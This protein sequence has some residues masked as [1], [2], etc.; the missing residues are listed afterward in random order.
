M[1]I[2]YIYIYIFPSTSLENLPKLEFW[3]ENKPSGNPAMHD[4]FG[5]KLVDGKVRGAQLPLRLGSNEN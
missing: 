5:L 1:A 2:K 4:L 3:F